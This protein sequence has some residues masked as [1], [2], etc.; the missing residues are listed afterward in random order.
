MRRMHIH[1]FGGMHPHTP[2]W[3]TLGVHLGHL[4][5]DPRFWAVL[6]L[7]VLFGLMAL[8]VILA[9]SGGPAPSTPIYPM[10]PYMP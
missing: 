9:G 6:A 3:H 7:A 2:D 10:S 4:A 1:T 5:H 8:A